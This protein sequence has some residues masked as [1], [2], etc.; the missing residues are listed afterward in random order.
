MA[1]IN[2]AMKRASIYGG[3]AIYG[4]SN[5]GGVAWLGWRGSIVNLA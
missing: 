5:N 2:G 3:M 1:E 4:L